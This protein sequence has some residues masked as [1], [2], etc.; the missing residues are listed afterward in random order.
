MIQGSILGFNGKMLDG[1]AFD[2][3]DES[4][5][6]SIEI[7]V[8]GIL[9]EVVKV[10]GNIPFIKNRGFHPTG[11]KCYWRV[12]LEDCLTEN[13]KCVEARVKGTEIYLQN[14]GLN[15]NREIFFFLHIP[16]SGGTT[17]RKLVESYLGSEAI[18]PSS[19]Q[20]KN[21]FG[22][23][24]PTSLDF[25]DNFGVYIKPETKVVFAH[26]PLSIVKKLPLNFKVVTILREPKARLLSHV[27]H[28]GRHQFKESRA[29]SFDSFIDMHDLSRR[30]T[31]VQSRMLSFTDQGVEVL[32]EEFSLIACNSS[33]EE[34]IM[35]VCEALGARLDGDKIPKYNHSNHDSRVDQW[36]RDHQSLELSKFIQ[37][38]MLLWQHISAKQLDTHLHEA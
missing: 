38:D 16:K 11:D 20:L 7:F 24:Y 21:D 18:F 1:W 15:P 10:D 5:G 22:G 30:L 26:I 37:L 3:R 9:R 29:K 28:F 8:D 27:K 34:S 36:I 35:E 4:R 33:L 12:D 23:S 2:S 13:S 32:K 31:D 19:D 25:L 17:V 6:L 14:S